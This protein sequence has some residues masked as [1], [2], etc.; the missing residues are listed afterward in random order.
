M[1]KWWERLKERTDELGWSH[2]ELARRAELDRTN[3]QKYLEGKV[4]NPRGD[5]MEK[6]ARAI[7]R[8]I[9]WLRLGLE[10]EP[11][12][13]SAQERELIEQIRDLPE[14]DQDTI[15]GLTTKLYKA[16]K[17]TRHKDDAA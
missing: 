3:V 1:Q 14:E 7:G 6:L 16:A 4:E 12:Q 17:A 9:S 10:T 15:R 2:T 5:A 8:P 13:L 11:M